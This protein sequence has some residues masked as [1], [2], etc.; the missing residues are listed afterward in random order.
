MNIPNL[1]QFL[2]FIAVIPATSVPI[3]YSLLPWWKSRLGQVMMI[4]SVGLAILIDIAA[5]QKLLG[6]EYGGRDA[7]RLVIFSLIAVGTWGI[8]F[9][10][11]VA[12]R[13]AREDLQQAKLDEQLETK[14]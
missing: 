10:Q 4:Q 8:F 11:F 5:A 2:I 7:I 12:R 9:Q 6:D 3:M 1:V 14:E 13:R